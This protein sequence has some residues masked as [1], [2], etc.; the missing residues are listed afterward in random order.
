MAGERSD[1]IVVGARC[2]GSPMATPLARNGLR[3]AAVERATVAGDTFSTHVFEAETLAFLGRLGVT[4]RVRATGAL[5]GYRSH[6][7]RANPAYARPG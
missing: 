1:A 4:D 5:I 3:V 6:R 7:V 2:A